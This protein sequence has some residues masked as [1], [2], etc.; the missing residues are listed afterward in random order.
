MSLASYATKN[1]VEKARESLESRLYTVKGELI[2]H[3]DAMEKRILEE[4][5]NGKEPSNDN[6]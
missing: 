5:R 6:T 2:G 3:M 4:I 1:D